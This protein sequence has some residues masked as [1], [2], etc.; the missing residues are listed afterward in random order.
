MVEADNKPLPFIN[1]NDELII[2][3]NARLMYKWWAGGQSVKL[4]LKELGRPDL[5]KTYRS[6][7]EGLP[8]KVE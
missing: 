8:F 2:P 5:L 1:G 7:L 6:Q 4:T 3:S